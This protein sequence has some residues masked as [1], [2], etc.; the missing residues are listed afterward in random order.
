MKRTAQTAFEFAR[1]TVKH[2]HV[3]RKS[4]TRRHDTYIKGT[5]SHALWKAEW[6]RYLKH[7]WPRPERNLEF[8]EPTVKANLVGLA[9]SGGGI[10]SATFNLGL[11]QSL[12]RVKLLKYID[13]LST[14]SGGSYI[15]SCLTKHLCEKDSQLEGNRFPFAY[16]TQNGQTGEERLEVRH[17]RN[18]SKFLAPQSGLF[19]LHTWHLVGTYL[20]GLLVLLP[21]PAS[22]LILLAGF[23]LDTIS[24]LLPDVSLIGLQSNDFWKEGLR[25]DWKPLT[26]QA[27]MTMWRFL[28]DDKGLG[29]WLSGAWTPGGLHQIL[30]MVIFGL[31]TVFFLTVLIFLYFTKSNGD[32]NGNG[33]SKDG[34]NSLKRKAGQAKRR[35]RLARFQAYTLMAT[36][37]VFLITILPTLVD[38]SSEIWVWLLGENTKEFIYHAGALALLLLLSLLF[39]LSANQNWDKQWINQLSLLIGKTGVIVFLLLLGLALLNFYLHHKSLAT[40]I[41]ILTLSLAF[42]FLDPNRASL[43]FFY[44]DRLAQAYLS[45]PQDTSNEFVPDHDLLLKELYPHLHDK[46]QYDNQ[47]FSAPYHLI[48]AAI[49]LTGDSDKESRLRGRKAHLF[50]F[51]GYYCGSE[52]T[53][54][55]DTT[56]YA[57]GEM[58]VATAIAISGAAAS[59]QMGMYTSRPL[60]ILMALLNIR[61]GSW[62]PNPKELP[63]RGD[64]LK[65]FFHELFALTSRD[66]PYVN[67]SDGGHFENLG[68]YSLIQR[69]CRYIIVSDVG[70][71]KDSLFKDLEEALRKIRI[72]FGVEIEDFNPETLKPGD[73]QYSQAAYAIGKIVY[74]SKDEGQKEY[75][76]LIYLKP[77]MFSDLPID[78]IHYQKKNTNFP[79]D[80][81][82]NQLFDEARF[83]N[84]RTLGYH[85]GKKI[86]SP[87]ENRANASNAFDIHAIFEP[88]IK[89]KSHPN[90]HSSVNGQSALAIDLVTKNPGISTA[91]SST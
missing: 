66:T 54:W 9:L 74:P 29:C 64:L 70:H 28:V 89:T 4:E 37:I 76:T 7:R 90:N 20:S 86:F 16:P 53:G 10:R 62:E 61:L 82:F 72:D 6:E 68:L 23:F 36:F 60:G 57:S 63:G 22:V 11:L 18:H 48:N 15:G 27:N 5:N 19:S 42:L 44:R 21:V 49:N 17:L 39:T 12:A 52:T 25:E 3:F 77:M 2:L 58:D 45:S 75:G 33:T 13:Y 8:T 51:A 47:T 56:E 14:V 69:R 50:E 73:S 78:I 35:E 43:H 26:C 65:T 80:S 71:D 59:P 1:K 30:T 88:I 38:L 24:T 31:L 67:L 46:K 55:R 79:H 40:F 32:S 85:I 83:E 41:S 87:C 81:T 84:Y 91:L 34:G